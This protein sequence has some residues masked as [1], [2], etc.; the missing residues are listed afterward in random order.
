MNWNDGSEDYNRIWSLRKQL[1]ALVGSVDDLID[2]GE[3][4]DGLPQSD[5]RWSAAVGQLKRE[6]D[7]SRRECKP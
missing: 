6:L 7:K 1:E 4:R 2:A 3:Q 5:A